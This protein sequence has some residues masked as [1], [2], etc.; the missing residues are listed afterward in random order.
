M[1]NHRKHTV[2]DDLELYKHIGKKI[3]EARTN[4]NRNIY[5]MNPNRKI[6][7]KFVTQTELGKAIGITFQQIQKYEK[8]QNKIPLD[9][10]VSLARYLKKP[11]S[12]FIPQL[13]E[14]LILKPEWE[15]KNVQQ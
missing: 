12:F 7:C 9:K 1:N 4:K 5:P 8:A 3:L 6:P 2:E 15:V 10:L 14:P 11:L 13:D